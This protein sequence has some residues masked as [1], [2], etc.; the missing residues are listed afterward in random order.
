MYTKSIVITEFF[1]HPCL[2]AKLSVHLTPVSV[3]KISSLILLK[4]SGIIGQSIDIL[5][6]SLIK[7]AVI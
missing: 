3:R 2:Q 4:A 7:K 5:M 1:S 6:H